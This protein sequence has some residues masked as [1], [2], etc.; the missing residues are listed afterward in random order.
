MA[1][2]EGSDVCILIYDGLPAQ[3]SA[4]EHPG[5]GVRRPVTAGDHHWEVSL[6]RADYYFFAF[7]S[8][9]YALGINVVLYALTH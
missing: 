2:R 8:Q 1:K 7:S 9:A 5:H 4:R 6:G 3:F